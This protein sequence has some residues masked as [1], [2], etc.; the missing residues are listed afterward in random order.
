[1]HMTL[2]LAAYIVNQFA[3]TTILM[4]NSMIEQITTD[5]VRTAYAK[6]V[7]SKK[8]ILKHALRNAL[9]PIATGFGDFIA[10]F[11]AGSL[12]IEKISGLDGI[13]LLTLDSLLN[14]DYPVVMGTIVLSSIAMMIG[15]LISDLS[16]TVI[17]PRIDFK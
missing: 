2:P 15:N 7:S 11:L 16:Y 10:I 9:I 17:D 4:K 3:F 13:G 14:R 6:G 12:L 1:M 5:Y 8:V